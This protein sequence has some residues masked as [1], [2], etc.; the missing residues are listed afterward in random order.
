[1][2]EGSSVEEVTQYVCL[3]EV[4]GPAQEKIR[5]CPAAELPEGA[6]AVTAVGGG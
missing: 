1:M 2:K 4:G 6:V 3:W 5:V